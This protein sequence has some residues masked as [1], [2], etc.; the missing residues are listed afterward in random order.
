[1]TKTVQYRCVIGD[2]L[3][4][5]NK[6]T[7]LHPISSRK[8]G[9]WIGHCAGDKSHPEHLFMIKTQEKWFVKY[10]KTDIF[11]TRW[12]DINKK[13]K[14][15][16]FDRQPKLRCPEGKCQMNLQKKS[17]ALLN[18]DNTDIYKCTGNFQ[19]SGHKEHLVRIQ[20]GGLGVKINKKELGV[21]IVTTES[22]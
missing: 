10:T 21:L 4:L 14:M 17:T 2:R 13:T 11:T 15:R 12:D 20:H 9:T 18:L 6:I 3:S 5:P 19:G 8:V 16:L 1:M 7:Y 22:D